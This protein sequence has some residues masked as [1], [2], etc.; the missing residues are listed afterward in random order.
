MREEEGGREERRLD[1][2]ECFKR[3]E[4]CSSL[5]IVNSSASPSAVEAK[6]VKSFSPTLSSSSFLHF[7]SNNAFS[8]SDRLRR[9]AIAFPVPRSS[10]RCGQAVRRALAQGRGQSPLPISLFTPSTSVQMRA[11]GAE[12]RVAPY[13][14]NESASGVERRPQLTP[15]PSTAS[16]SANCCRSD[17]RRA[18]LPLRLKH[19]PR[20]PRPPPFRLCQTRKGLLQPRL[21]GERYGTLHALL[22]PPTTTA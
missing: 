6:A 18:S 10:P 3:V 4:G 19:H 5:L 11:V 9:R 13:C 21:D 12:G 14:R 22:D 20:A 15:S 7:H 16:S 17:S 8:S 2:L 1:G